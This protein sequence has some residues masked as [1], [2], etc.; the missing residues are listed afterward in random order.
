MKRNGHRLFSEYKKQGL[1]IKKDNFCASYRL[2]ILYLT[3]VI[4]IDFK[5]AVLNLYYQMLL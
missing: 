3:K 2:Y 5:S 4:G 1:A